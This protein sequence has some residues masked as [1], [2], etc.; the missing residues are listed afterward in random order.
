MLEWLG[1]AFK[2]DQALAVDVLA[3]R[4]V[5]ALIFGCVVAAIYHLTYRSPEPLSPSF[6]A[7]L[8]LL[9]ILIAIITQVIGESQARAFSLVGALA[10]IRFRTV[11]QDTRDTVFVIFAVAVGMAVGAGYLIFTLIGSAVVGV[12]AWLI[13]PRFFTGGATFVEDFTLTVR[14]SLGPGLEAAVES[15]ID[16]YVASRELLAAATARQGAAFDISYKIRLRPGAAPTAF[17]AELNR[18][19]GVQTVELRRA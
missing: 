8:V 10:I 12:A 11:V 6:L 17:V 13:P 14:L 9:A 3:I 19:E 18:L 7:T 4:L 5:A 15:A 16:R 1:E 2:A